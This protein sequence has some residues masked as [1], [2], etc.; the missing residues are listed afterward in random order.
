MAFG[1]GFLGSPHCTLM[2]GG[3]AMAITQG[4]TPR[5]GIVWYLIGRI[6]SY[7][8]LGGL[9]GKLGEVLVHQIQ[10][11]SFW[12]SL[13]LL[14]GFAALGTLWFFSARSN[15]GGLYARLVSKIHGF[16]QAPLW[17]G[18]LTPLLPCG[19][20]GPVWMVAAALQSPYSGA[21]L[22]LVFSLS[23]SPA[24]G[25]APQV[26]RRLSPKWGAVLSGV[27]ILATLWTRSSSFLRSLPSEGNSTRSTPP[28]IYCQPAK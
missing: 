3:I 25:L 24:L 15:S 23:T 22:L 26:R 20:L 1:M 18:L 7:T 4:R 16:P 27:L 28:Q 11:W 5:Q 6:T 10:S 2:C 12:S 8:L 14:M 17:V 13:A 21:L 19:F 9:L